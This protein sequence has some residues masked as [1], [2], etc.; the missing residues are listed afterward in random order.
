MLDI[1]VEPLVMGPAQLDAFVKDE[2]QKW[3]AIIQAAGI[4]IE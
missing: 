1:G 2:R 4:R 3:G